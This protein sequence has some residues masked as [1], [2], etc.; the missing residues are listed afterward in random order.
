MLAI[1]SLTCIIW[2]NSIN[3]EIILFLWT[4][5]SLFKPNTCWEVPL[6][7]QQTSHHLFLSLLILFC[8]VTDHYMG[9]ARY[10]R[11]SKTKVT[12]LMTLVSGVHMQGAVYAWRHLSYFTAHH[13]PNYE[14][15]KAVFQK[16]QRK[17]STKC[18]SRSFLCFLHPE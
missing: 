11:L 4:A 12:V 16:L 14:G 7:P 15:W 2:L 1:L 13:R 17:R 3:P 5:E 10:D 9:M 6:G 18:P 8:F